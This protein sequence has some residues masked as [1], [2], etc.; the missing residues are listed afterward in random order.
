MGAPGL[1][2]GRELA[3]PSTYCVLATS[4][5]TVLSLLPMLFCDRKYL[6]QLGMWFTPVITTLCEAEAGGS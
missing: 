5:A 3:L 2:V 4:L 6:F 1:S